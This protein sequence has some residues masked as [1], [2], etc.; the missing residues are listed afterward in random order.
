MY[1]LSKT[2][3]HF[4]TLIVT[5]PA[6]SSGIILFVRPLEKGTLRLNQLAFSLLLFSLVGYGTSQDTLFY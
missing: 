6:S 1:R 5:I 2:E 3:A 4:T